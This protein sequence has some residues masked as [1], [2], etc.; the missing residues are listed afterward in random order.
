MMCN[1]TAYGAVPGDSQD[2]SA[3]TLYRRTTYN[4]VAQSAL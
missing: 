2:C 1:C 4:G 3:L